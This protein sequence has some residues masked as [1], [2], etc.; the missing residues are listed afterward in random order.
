MANSRPMII[1][2]GPISI[3]G[4]SISTLLA[5]IS[6]V[7]LVLFFL[8]FHHASLPTTSASSSYSEDD[9]AD[10]LHA[11]QHYREKVANS[12]GSPRLPVPPAIPLRN[13]PLRAPSGD[14]GSVPAPVAAIVPVQQTAEQIAAARKAAFTE[15]FKQNIWGST[16]S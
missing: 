1:R 6:F 15:I 2:A 5:I 14:Q 12:D 10:A 3:R 16:E 7:G 4:R 9:A 11:Q 8:P 13:Q